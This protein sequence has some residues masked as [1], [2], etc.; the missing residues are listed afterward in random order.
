MGVLLSLIFGIG[1]MLL[2][3]VFVYWLDR[4]EKEPKL[5][6]G[7]VFTWGAIVAA[8]GAFL[9]NSILGMGIYLFT[10]SESATQFSTLTVI[11]PIVEESLK[12]L[13]I[14]LV[15]LIFR[16]EFDSLLD[17]VVYAAIVA[18]GF[19]ATENSFYIYTQ[20]Y[21]HAGME[22]LVWMAFVR[23]ILVGWQHPFYTSFIGIGLAISRMNRH[24][25]I[26]L[27]APALGWG[28]AV[29]AHSLHNTLAGLLS[30]TGATGLVVGATFDWVG[31]FFMFLFVI[32]FIV[33][34]QRALTAQLKDE[35]DR[36]VMT[37]NQYNIACSAWRQSQAHTQIGRAH[38]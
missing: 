4:Y 22:G 35:V 36:G 32:W 16:R 17:G 7:G 20:G 10:G 28:C 15:Y 8:G 31:W 38:V 34:E 37:V 33:R 6:L 29:V 19:A 24:W 30:S 9:L 13:A 25:A 3:A 21:Q 18:L 12:G 14:L 1:P 5:L 2:C 11:A 23:V 27:L 26:K